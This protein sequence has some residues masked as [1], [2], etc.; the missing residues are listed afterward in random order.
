MKHDLSRRTFL[1]KGLTAGI[2]LTLMNP[3]L[4]AISSETIVLAKKSRAMATIIL[5]PAPSSTERIAAN[6]LA[7][8]LYKIT[9]ATFPIRTTD[10][11][12]KGTLI[13]I[14]KDIKEPGPESFRIQTRGNNLSLTGFDDA[15]VEF[16]VYTFLEK[17]LGVRWLWPGEL[18]EVVPGNTTL[19]IGKIDDAQ[20]PDFLWRD[21][22]PGGALWG[23][24]SG[25]TEMHERARL[26]GITKEHQEEVHR[27]ERRNKW[28]GWKVYGGH[29]IAEIFPPQKYSSAHPEYYAWVNGKRAVP[30]PDFDHKHGGQVC[31]TEP[32]VISTAAEWVNNFYDDHPDYQGVH[33]SMNDSGGFCECDRCRSLD[34][35]KTMGGGGIDAQETK[36][37]TARKA[38]ITDRIFTFANQ[39]AER[40]QQRHP[41]K[42]IFC[43]AYGPMI[44]PPEKIQLHPNVVPQYTLWSAYKHANPGLKHEHETIAAAWA[45]KAKLAGIYEYHING[46]WPGMHRLTPSYYAEN[47]RFL[48]Q[49][50]IKLY[51]T[52]SGDEFSTNDLNY[53]VTGKL[54]WN[55]SQDENKILADFY[56]KGFGNSGPAIRR[57]HERL[58]KAWIDA[59][60]GGHDVTC[61][62]IEDQGLSELFNDELMTNCTNDLDTASGAAPTDVIRQRVDFLRQGLKYTKLTVN[63]VTAVKALGANP[64]KQS[65]S[66]ALD[67]CQHRQQFVEE[68]KND[69]IFPYFWVRY[70]D[71]QRSFLPSIAHL[72]A[73]LDKAEG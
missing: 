39:V 50:G 62:S 72:Q 17:Y 45:E 42:Y 53:Y 16:A 29:N 18:G 49:K 20:K 10:K 27:W 36:G 51:Q 33:I 14:G 5:P 19:S 65:V 30:G 22:G 55:A 46:S 41:G 66:A 70:N 28:G 58:E 11:K 25:P 35:G 54:L 15:G 34:T 26:M 31:T 24:T 69:Y 37:P 59:T 3:V 67:A 6:E 1:Q 12:P 61:N 7:S 40:V 23:A 21:R 60:R 48:R 2:G 8:Y 47:I 63:A 4:S 43:F 38:I 73:L 52:Q 9:G 64:K 32:G 57:F 68:W 13:L 56:E 71:E 44:L